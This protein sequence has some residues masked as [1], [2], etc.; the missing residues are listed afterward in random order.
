[1]DGDADSNDIAIFTNV[2]LGL[3]TSPSHIAVCDLDNSGTP[4]GFDIQPFV[5]ALLSP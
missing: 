1:M 3:D 4:N 2:L 5:D